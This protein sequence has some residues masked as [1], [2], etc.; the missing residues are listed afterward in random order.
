MFIDASLY[1]IKAVLLHT[2]NVLPSI[3]IAHSVTLRETYD[4]LAFILDRIKYK[5][6]QWLICADLKVVAILNGL[7][8]GYTKFMCFLCTWDSRMK[9]EHYTRRTWPPQE[10]YKLGSHNVIHEPF[11]EKEKI[12]LPNLHIKLGI[13]KQFV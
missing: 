5:D 7:Q 11:V 12:I 6:H 3:P 13:T 10:T 4:N 2:R 1:S 9:S 8:S